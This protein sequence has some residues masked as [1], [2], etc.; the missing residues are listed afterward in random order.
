ML[1][2][3]VHEILTFTEGGVQYRL[4]ANL[5]HE[6]DFCGFAVMRGTDEAV[7]QL[8]L[9]S[10]KQGTMTMREYIQSSIDEMNFKMQE[11]FGGA[12]NP[13]NPSTFWCDQMWQIMKTITFAPNPEGVPQFKL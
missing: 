3:G 9:N 7:H 8:L 1:A 13:T 10:A 12:V 2:E 5:N 4:V 11:T 6:F